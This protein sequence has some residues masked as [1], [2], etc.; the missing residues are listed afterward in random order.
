MSDLGRLLTVRHGRIRQFTSFERDPDRG[1]TWWAT[2]P[3]PAKRKRILLEPGET[4][5]M[6]ALTGPGMVTRVWMTT[7]VP[8]NRRALRDLVLRFYWDGETEP[9]VRSPLGDF[10]GAP[11]GRYV[12]YVSEPLSL[13]SGGFCSSWLMPYATAAR[14]EVANE[15]TSVVD[16]LYYQI[17][18]LRGVE[19]ESPLR[20]HAQ[21]RRENPTAAGVP[22]TVV[23]AR[24]TGHYVGCH[25][26]I[27]NRE[28]WLRP[29]L[30]E[31][32]YP[33]GFGLGVLEGQEGI[34]VDDD[35]GPSLQGTGTEDFFNAGWYFSRGTYAGPSCGCTVRDYF[36][37]RV[38]AYRFDLTAPI[39]FR[40]R[41]RVTLDHGLENRLST[42]YASVAYWYQQEPHA[43]FEPMLPA[44]A[45]RPS[46][47][48]VNLLQG[49]L[50]LA[51]FALAAG[52]IIWALL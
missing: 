6:A 26:F 25:A 19:P 9:S 48:A 2:R 28:W 42:D 43:P 50:L 32:V 7:L 4:H 1:G 10:F 8:V 51:P 35:N 13:G 47:V 11:F 20:F 52:A 30:N 27:Q 14:L 36:R 45:R 29:R 46:S 24:G 23:E 44:A 31:I 15:G 22:Y 3:A 17:G 40:D 38:A 33:Y 41:L 39:P 21:W 49:V 16:P 34:W 37:G 12:P 18:V 5:T